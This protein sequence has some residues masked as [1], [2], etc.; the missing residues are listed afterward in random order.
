MGTGEWC[1]HQN[2][3]GDEDGV[4][5]Q[6]R[7]S[8]RLVRHDQSAHCSSLV[9]PKHG[10]RHAPTILPG[11]P[12]ITGDPGCRLRDEHLASMFPAYDTSETA[13]VAV[14]VPKDLRDSSTAH[15]EFDFLIFSSF[16][17]FTFCSLARG[18]ERNGIS[19]GPGRCHEQQGA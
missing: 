17:P 2:G 7:T 14:D 11:H 13:L 4:S 5:F 15:P 8:A 18:K 10:L 3:D 9:R 1:S 12:V 6:A 19:W 16:H